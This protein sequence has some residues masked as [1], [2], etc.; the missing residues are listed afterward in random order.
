[1]AHAL[2][3]NENVIS[4]HWKERASERESRKIELTYIFELKLTLNW[5]FVKSRIEMPSA[6]YQFKQNNILTVS[7][8]IMNGLP[9]YTH[10]RAYAHHVW[11]L[12]CQ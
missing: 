12:Q 11:H 5:L 8:R 2:N 1:M 6:R 4:L 7:G 3:E 9:T 10:M